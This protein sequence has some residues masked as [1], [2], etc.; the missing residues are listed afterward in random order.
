MRKFLSFLGLAIALLVLFFFF[1]VYFFSFEPAHPIIKLEKGW[2]VTYH[3][4]Q[5]LNTNLEHLST[6]VG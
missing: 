3:N 1:A 4:Q 5:Y 6:Q 2:T